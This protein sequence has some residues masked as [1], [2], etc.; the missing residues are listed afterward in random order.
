MRGTPL[1]FATPGRHRPI[2]FSPGAHRLRARLWVPA[3]MCALALVARRHLCAPG[4]CTAPGT[5]TTRRTILWQHGRS[6]RPSRAFLPILCGAVPA[7][8]CKSASLP[9]HS[10]PRSPR[11]AGPAR[12][13]NN[14][15]GRVRGI[16]LSVN[17]IPYPAWSQI[18]VG[19]P[20]RGN[21]KA[22]P[23]RGD[24]SRLPRELERIAA[25]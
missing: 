10:G 2:H 3:C 11:A 21:P 12:P 13:Q 9:A 19:N 7:C 24:L 16:C 15:S 5:S 1:P 14:V 4:D 6:D 17:L 25:G 8:T 23:C 20:C 22:N 18:R